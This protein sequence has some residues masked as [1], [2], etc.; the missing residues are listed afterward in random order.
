[1]LDWN[2][3][4]YYGPETHSGFQFFS[5]ERLFHKYLHRPSF[6]DLAIWQEIDGV[7]V[8]QGMALGQPS[9]AKRQLNINWVERSFAPTYLR[10]GALLPIL[11]C[12]EEYA[13][14]LGS[15]RVVVKDAVD[16]SI[17]A[18]YGY[19]LVRLSHGGGVHPVKEL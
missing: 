15:S 7:N 18:R 9:N 10:C 14:L 12:A 19:N 3:P 16:P 11:A 1:M 17:Y 4:K 2:G 8:L 6:F 5:W 13:K